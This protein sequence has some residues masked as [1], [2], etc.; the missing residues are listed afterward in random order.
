MKDTEINVCKD[1]DPKETIKYLKWVLNNLD[2]ET[3][4]I[5]SDKSYYGTYSLR[6]V[7]KDTDIG[8]NGKGYTKDLA[9]ASAYGEFFERYL[10]MLLTENV[11]VNNSDHW[12]S[13]DE[14]FLTAEEIVS[15]DCEIINRIIRVNKVQKNLKAKTQWFKKWFKA[16]HKD[17]YLC[18]PIINYSSNK[19][20][21]MPYAVKMTTYG[22][23]GMVAGNTKQE[24]LVE[25][26]SEIIERY[27]Q[28]QV[29]I[30]KLCL[31]DIPENYINK[32][33]SIKN[34]WSK[35]KSNSNYDA[36][37]KDASLG[38][39]W[40]VVVLVVIN[41][42]TSNYGISFGA[43]P[44]FEIAAQRSFTE[45]TQGK[46]LEKFSNYIQI[47]NDEVEFESADNW[48]NIFT[49][50]I[51]SYPFE[52]FK[53]NPDYKFEKFHSRCHDNKILLKNLTKLIDRH[54]YQI[55]INDASCFNIP[56]YH[57]IIPGMSEMINT[58]EKQIKL[59]YDINKVSFLL[60]DIY[61]IDTTNVKFIINTINAT[62]HYNQKNIL[63]FFLPTNNC[64]DKIPWGTGIVG[65]MYFVS[66]LYFLNK[67]YKCAYNE[68]EQILKLD[69]KLEQI[70]V[71][72]LNA[73]KY[74]FMFRYKKFTH[75]KAVEILNK[76][77]NKNIVDY[78]NFTFSSEKDVIKK[79]Y[80]NF[81]K[82]PKDDN[83]LFMNKKSIELNKKLLK[84]REMSQN[85]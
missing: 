33:P 72:I 9:R 14:K 73:I 24:A 80:P 4:E 16:D 50:G 81:S 5:W 32:F 64:K 58:T 65:R 83:M 28:K 42:K 19:Q 78:V 13:V 70:R 79:Q 68:I 3:E 54:H 85:L 75:K 82:L 43:H 26:I 56:A 1:K 44:N 8:A 62:Q 74:Y 36:Y 6:L 49:G 2:I 21:Y 76:F 7:V 27:V 45:A 61:R 30:K 29:V 18:V 15:Q 55:W 12:I 69:L 60:W 35:L 23:N 77:F 59:A 39:Q 66:M 63:N 37:L 25:G 57:I 20:C 31:P 38:G 48:Q 53:K 17:K 71:A 10:N 34:M 52:F 67:D 11:K 41:K 22:S 40:P 84:C 46:S 47:Y 51:K